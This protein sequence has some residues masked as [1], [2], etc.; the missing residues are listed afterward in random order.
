ML[1]YFHCFSVFV[2]TGEN[3]SDTLRVG[4]YLLKTEEKISVFKNIKNIR[5]WTGPKVTSRRICIH[6]ILHE[7]ALSSHET[8]EPALYSLAKAKEVYL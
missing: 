1:S 5:I 6:T 3:D 2:W 7:S 8:S 4:V